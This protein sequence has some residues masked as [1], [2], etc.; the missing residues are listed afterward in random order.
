MPLP[1]TL[2]L[3]RQLDYWIEVVTLIVPGLND[4]DDEL[5]AIADFITDISPEIPWHVTAFHP[6]YKM[7]A[8]RRTP[9]ETLLRAHDIG[10]SAGLRFVYP[11]NAAGQ[12]GDRENTICPDCGETLITRRG[13]RV[14]DNHLRDGKCPACDTVIPGVWD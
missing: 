3:L 11:G 1:V 12:V 5:T 13:F 9:A 7:T 10:R 4:E 14:A 2:R 8:P 6:D